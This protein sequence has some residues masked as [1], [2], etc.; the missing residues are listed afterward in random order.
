MQNVQNAAEIQ[1]RVINLVEIYRTKVGKES[2]I[3]KNAKEDYEYW[4]K[5]NEEEMIEAFNAGEQFFGGEF[6]G[7]G[8]HTKEWIKYLSVNEQLLGHFY[9]EIAKEKAEKEVL[10]QLLPDIYD[11]TIFTEEEESFLKDHFKEMVNYIILTPCDDSL[12]WVHRHDGKDAY[13]I[14]CE[15]LELIKSRVE[16]AAGARVYYPYTNLAQLATL[17]DGCKYYCDTMPI[18]WTRI[19]IYANNID[20]EDNAE[21]S[22]Y[23]AVLSYIS[24][25]G[26][27]NKEVALLCEAY[28]NLP[29]GGKFVLI[30]SSSILAAKDY[31][32]LRQVLVKDKAIREI[33][34]LPQVMSRNASSDT[35][36]LIAEKGNVRGVTTFI[37]A[38][39]AAIKSEKKNYSYTLDLEALNEMLQNQGHEPS[40]GLRK[41]VNVACKDMQ[42]DILVPQVYV[43]EKPS[44]AEHPVPLSAVCS[45]ES[46]LIRD[47]QYDLP[48]DTPWIT[49]SDLTPLF[50]G[51][52][53][54]SAIK[55]ADCPNNPRFVEGSKDYA[56]N[57]DGQFE[58][59]LFA[60]M[61]TKKGYHVLDYR[62]SF[63]LD[64]NNDTVLYK[65]SAE[66]GVHIVVVRATGNAYAVNKGILVFRPKDG[67]KT[68]SLAALLRLPIVYRQLAAY[69]QYGIA[70]HL[71]DIL[72]PMDKRVIG[73]EL[74]RMKREETVTNEL[75]EKVEAM[76]TEY[77]NE[78]RMRK[79][80]MG[81]KVFD[82]INTEDLMRYYVENRDT[83]SDLWPQIEEQ[84]NHLRNTIHELSE[85]LD[86]LSQE[87]HFGSPE[88]I[89]L[90][91]YLG[92]LQHSNN[93]N[94]FTL[95][96]HLD[97][98]N[99]IEFQENKERKNE[100]SVIVHPTVWI[101]K[102]DIHRVVGNIVSNA[103]KHGFID[104]TRA[105]YK[106]EI[107]LSFNTEK[108]MYQIDFR[109][110]GQP[111]PE[112][113]N[114]MRY[115]IKGEKAGITA[116]TGIGGNVI[117]S[118]VEHYNG[119]YDVFMDGDWTVVRIYLPKAI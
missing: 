60:Q 90:D 74:S 64:G 54:M 28:K 50:T 42:A 26:D 55:K 11:R 107:C 65:F 101:A 79:H 100:R 109:N 48:E 7:E 2:Y 57:E 76:K 86:H 1:Q 13:T 5:L 117:K 53:D 104:D 56:F 78:V 77:I 38:R 3:A 25:V 113:L 33:I 41:M 9:A 36:V 116:G 46:T 68:N 59:N 29:L 82:L 91:E 110:N 108:G 8:P 21:P 81:Q 119:D 47:V 16:I 6:Y 32:Q 58:D 69:E 62:Q 4:E 118:I 14:P 24:E 92:N 67:Y 44:E 12:K 18:A 45:L 98:N 31:Q 71:D 37:D 72:V 40:T 85:M 49:M 106:L 103:Q 80:D 94:G 102:N 99:I 112:G 114:K 22:S 84:L 66:Q 61:G 93:V 105:D 51:D 115:G 15:V 30:C 70:E 96:Y 83:E 34:Q 35:C 89:N 95:S 52:I 43:V 73:D 111:L 19:V 17:Y 63:Y 10:D 23:D 27:D 20:A 87:E 39:F 88:L 75:G 97:R